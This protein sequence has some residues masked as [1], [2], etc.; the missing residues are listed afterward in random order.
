MSFV[1]PF[2]FVYFVD[3]GDPLFFL[4]CFRLEKPKR[5]K[6]W[7]PGKRLAQK[8]KRGKMAFLFNRFF[9][10]FFFVPFTRNRIANDFS[11]KYKVLKK[12]IPNYSASRSAG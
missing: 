4:V 2:R 7:E 11:L 6:L 1:C 5:N 9:F 10:C 3:T 12:I 8:A